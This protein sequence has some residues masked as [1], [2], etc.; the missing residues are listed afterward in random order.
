MADL[1]EAMRRNDRPV[2]PV[3]EPDEEL[4]MRVHQSSLNGDHVEISAIR[5]RIPGQS[6]NRSKYSEPECV[7]LPSYQG[8]GI[9][10]LKCGDIPRRGIQV[11]DS[12]E[13]GF[14][15]KHDPLEDNYS[16]TELHSYK[17]KNGEVV[18]RIKSSSVKLKIRDHLAR[19]MRII[20]KPN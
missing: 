10:S 18:S 20:K 19:N 6:F 16:H 4:Y 13:Y 9:G 5:I 14:A 11:N 3:F 12:I 1:P 2:D 7:L 17:V 15:P 8:F